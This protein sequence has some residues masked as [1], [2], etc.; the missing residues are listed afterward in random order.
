[1]SERGREGERKEG[2]VAMGSELFVSHCFPVFCLPL[3]F[4]QF[5]DGDVGCPDSAVTL[6]RCYG[7]VYDVTS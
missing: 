5:V 2:E 1:M 7:E 6:V 3:R 4:D